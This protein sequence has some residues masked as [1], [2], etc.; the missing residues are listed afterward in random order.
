MPVP[1][2]NIAPLICS[3]KHEKSSPPRFALWETTVKP[4]LVASSLISSDNLRSLFVAGQ[5]LIKRILSYSLQSL[6][7]SLTASFFSMIIEHATAEKWSY[8]ALCKYW[9]RNDIPRAPRWNMSYR[10]R[11]FKVGQHIDAYWIV[12]EKIIENSKFDSTIFH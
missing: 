1:R 8:G 3:W 6:R 12:V 10:N 9:I 2:L 5:P 7:Q 11:V 4:N